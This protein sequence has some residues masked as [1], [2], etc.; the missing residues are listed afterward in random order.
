MEIN[1]IIFSPFKADGNKMFGSTPAKNW[2]QL[3]PDSDNGM[4]KWFLRSLLINEGENCI[5]IDSGFGTNNIGL[6]TEYGVENIKNSFEILKDQ[7]L[8]ADKITHSIHTH[9]HVDHCGGSFYTNKNSEL[10]P[11]FTN[12]QY[13]ISSKQFNVARNPTEFEKESFEP[14]VIK[15]FANHPNL[16]LIE[17]ECFLFPWLELLMFNGHTE[18]LLIPVI[19]TKKQSIVFTGDLIPSAAHLQLKS[20]MS[21]DVNQLLSLAEREQFLEEAY[22]NE[23][24]LFFQHDML[25]EC[26]TLKKENGLILPAEFMYL[27]DIL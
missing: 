2:Q 11:S 13:I 26:C 4:C 25:N 12:A 15:A 16:K 23:Y 24:I 27:Y 18:G 8:N 7:N 6:L 1:T 20:T 14:E 19:H 22:E 10:Q 3:Y 17:N 9:L 5:L 21:Y